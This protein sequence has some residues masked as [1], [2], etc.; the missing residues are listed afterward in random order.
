MEISQQE[1]FY[2][3][4]N[5]LA[6][7]HII[8][9]VTKTFQTWKNN[10]KQK[11]KKSKFQPKKWYPTGWVFNEETQKWDPP[12]YI[13]NEASQRWE[14]DAEKGIWID[15]FQQKKSRHSSQTD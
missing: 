9:R 8:Q 2:F 10:R 13:A 6:L 12:D 11:R 7:F 15:K 5:I 3:L 14:W 4:L 1:L